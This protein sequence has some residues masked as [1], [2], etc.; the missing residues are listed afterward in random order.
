MCGFERDF[1]A[2]AGKAIRDMMADGSGERNLAY[3][4]MM[5]TAAGVDAQDGRL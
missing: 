2:G 4:A 5:W 1:G 3:S